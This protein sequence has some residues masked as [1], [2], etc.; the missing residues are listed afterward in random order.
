MTKTLIVIVLSLNFLSLAYSQLTYTNKDQVHLWGP[1]EI[2]H[3]RA[4]PYKEWYQESYDEIT[5]TLEAYKYA[6]LEDTEVTIFIG[7][8]CGDTKDYFPKFMKIWDQAGLT[9]DQ[10]NIIALKNKDEFYKAGPN[11]EE[12]VFGIHRVPTFIF[13]RD[14]EEIGRI[15]E[16]PVND[17]ET[18]I[19]QIAQ[20]LPSKPSYKGVTAIQSY[21][22]E[23]DIDSIYNDYASLARSMFGET[24]H[25]GELTTYASKLYSDGKARE[26]EFVYTLNTRIHRYHPYSYY[27][28]GDFLFDCEDYA[29]AKEMFLKAQAIAANYSDTQEYLDKITIIEANRKN[30]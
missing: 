27:R 29:K 7:T 23:T 19:A 3:V 5:P 4:E 14:G 11:Q 20:G 30:N 12:Q 24:K 2:E 18:D 8:W 21:I 9:E 13:T 26:A 10:V 16:T 1:V 17:L 6:P 25:V 22:S 15:V 28:L